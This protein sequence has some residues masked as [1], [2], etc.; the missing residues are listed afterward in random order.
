LQNLLEQ[1]HLLQRNHDNL[2]QQFQEIS[3]KLIIFKER[4][5]QHQQQLQIYK[6]ELNEKNHQIIGLEKQTAVLADQCSRLQKNLSLS[7]DKIELLREEKLFLTQEKSNLF[8]QVNLIDKSRLKN[9]IDQ[10]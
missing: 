8:N 4:S 1:P 10:S 2:I 7:Q 3:R 9:K 5:E 6:N